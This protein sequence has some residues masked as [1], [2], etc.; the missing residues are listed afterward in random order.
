MR[1]F[2]LAVGLL[3]LLSGCG[4]EEMGRLKGRLVVN[5]QPK[6]FPPSSASVQ[7]SLIGADGKPDVTK[8]YSAVVNPDGT[9]EVVAS[10]GKLHPG[11]YQV[12]IRHPPPK[13]GAAPVTITTRREVKPGDNDWTID[14]ANPEG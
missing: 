9:F 1:T 13:G 3:S 6:E 14:L 11:T 7:I 4:G 12:E 2:I 8:A 5:G 10:G